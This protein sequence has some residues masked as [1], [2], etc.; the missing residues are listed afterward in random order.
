[1]FIESPLRTYSTGMRMRLAFAV[2]IHIDP[3]VLLID[4][5]LAVGDIAFQR[6]CLA[7]VSEFKRAGCTIFLVSHDPAQIRALCDDILYLKDGRQVAFGPTLE[8]M[9]LYERTTADGERAD[10][11]GQQR[12]AS[13]AA[14]SILAARLTSA[15][16]DPLDTIMPGAP[17]S[18]EID[19]VVN[20]PLRALKASVSVKRE[21]HLICFDS[22]TDATHV[23]PP[24][25]G[26][27]R[28]RLVIER[29]DL[30][31]GSYFVSVGLYD[32]HWQICHD[33]IERSASFVVVG[34]S[35]SGLGILNPPCRWGVASAAPSGSG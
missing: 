24:A 4:E 15:Q 16:G 19:Y 3:D 34:Q 32:E 29:L 2:A 13:E 1:E 20:A 5:V 23:E 26:R 33:A 31:P 6:K 17:L 12:G 8:T 7:K 22:N 27:A 14:A 21:D 28:L 11:S 30:A 9:A 25:A 10:A 18:I 35:V